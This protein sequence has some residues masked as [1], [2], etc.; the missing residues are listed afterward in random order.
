MSWA[1]PIPAAA[2]TSPRAKAKRT[3]VRVIGVFLSPGF[4][5]RTDTLNETPQAVK[6]RGQVSTFDIYFS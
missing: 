3:D 6:P 1:K 2:R 4:R 5:A